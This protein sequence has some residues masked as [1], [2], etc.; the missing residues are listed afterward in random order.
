MIGHLILPAQ[1]WWQRHILVHLEAPTA[2]EILALHDIATVEF[3]EEVQLAFGRCEDVAAP[4]RPW[5]FRK[6]TVISMSR[7]GEASEPQPGD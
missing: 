4:S 7:D 3:G 6:P 1:H 5:T 2:E